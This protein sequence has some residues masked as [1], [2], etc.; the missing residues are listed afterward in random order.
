ML[1]DALWPTLVGAGGGF[2]A[3]W[4]LQRADPSDRLTG[5]GAALGTGLMLTAAMAVIGRLFVWLDG[6]AAPLFRWLVEGLAVDDLGA[7]APQADELGLVLRM[8]GAGG[9]LLLY[10]RSSSVR[11]G[12]PVEPASHRS[13]HASRSRAWGLSLLLVGVAAHNLWLGQARGPLLRGQETASWAALTTM[14]LVSVLPALAAVAV[15]GGGGGGRVRLAGAAGMLW[16]S[17]L[18]GLVHPQ[19]SHSLVAGFLPLLLGAAC[20]AY[21]MGLVLNAIERLV[22]VGWQTTLVVISGAGLGYWLNRLILRLV[23]VG[24]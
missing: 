14:G 23:A 12:G 24:A 13:V 1:W 19:A 18:A 6:L 15:V 5:Y 17:L 21:A 11:R 16:L 20:L 2:L 9:I 8:V 7:L 10:L 4:G 22:G 3:L